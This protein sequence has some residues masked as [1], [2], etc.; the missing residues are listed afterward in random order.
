MSDDPVQPP[1]H[2][3]RAVLKSTIARGSRPNRDGN[4]DGAAPS[5]DQCVDVMLARTRSGL[6]L[7]LSGDLDIARSAPLNLLLRQLEHT[8]TTLSIDLGRVPFADCGG[9]APFMDSAQRRMRTGLPPLLFVELSPAV[10]RIMKT[11][12]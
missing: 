7:T 12:G 6:R 11:F 8:P 4:R 5:Q 1:G 9:L 2:R 3:H 10:A